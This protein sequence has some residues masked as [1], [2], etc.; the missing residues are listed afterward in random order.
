MQNNLSINEK[1]NNS[2]PLQLNNEE[3]IYNVLSSCF[4][5][6]N[7]VINEEL[8]MKFIYQIVSQIGRKHYKSKLD[9]YQSERSNNKQY[10]EQLADDNEFV[11]I[12]RRFYDGDMFKSDESIKES[13]KNS[14]DIISLRLLKLT[15]VFRQELKDK[16]LNDSMEESYKVLYQEMHKHYENIKNSSEYD[17]GL[18]SNEVKDFFK[19]HASQLSQQ[20]QNNVDD[21]SNIAEE[22][23]FAKILQCFKW[24]WNMIVKAWESLCNS[25]ESKAVD[26][27]ED[28]NNIISSDVLFNKYENNLEVPREWA[29]YTKTVTLL[30]EIQVMAWNCANTSL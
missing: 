2:I 23:I 20:Q 16:N 19:I 27:N 17:E 30:N 9:K 8:Y 22:G 1:M 3:L 7:S 18:S 5:N 13:I 28:I 14:A 26:D 4:D 25:Q 29:N 21:A 12:Y 6:K 10:A 15:L 11:N 24:L